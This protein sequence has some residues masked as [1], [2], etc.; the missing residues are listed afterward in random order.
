LNDDELPRLLESARGGDWD[1]IEDLLTGMLA[2]T[3]DAALHLTGDPAK[4]GTVAEDAL[5][6]VLLSVTSGAWKEGDPLAAAACALAKGAAGGPAPFETS[7]TPED[8]VAI[9]RRP[10]DA[11][12]GELARV[13]AADRVIA[14]LAYALDLA[15]DELAPALGRPPAEVA[16][17]IERVLAAIPH[18]DPAQ[19]FRDVL[20][21]RA[22][23]ARVPG[24]L[25][26]RVL[27]RLEERRL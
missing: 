7:L 8:L 18:D 19:A 2:P 20:D 21:T 17:A 9:G 24:D 16:G 12:R 5:V 11:R 22:A 14:V 26:D 3:F 13:A 25:E 27:D 6:D 4:A 1:A 10:D 23:R 15:P